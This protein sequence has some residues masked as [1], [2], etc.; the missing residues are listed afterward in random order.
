MFQHISTDRAYTSTIVL[1]SLGVLKFPDCSQTPIPRDESNTVG[2]PAQ[3]RWMGRRGSSPWEL[4]KGSHHPRGLTQPPP[5]PIAMVHNLALVICLPLCPSSCHHGKFVEGQH[6]NKRR[7]RAKELIVL[8]C[9]AG[10]DSK[11]P[12]DSKQIKPVNL[13]RI[14]IGR[15]DAEVEAPILWSPEGKSQF[16]EKDP[17]IGKD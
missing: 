12:S 13:L 1:P 2:V 17:D 15:T 9:G 14:L 5:A 16:T 3:T 4:G 10:E 11:S 8:N 7:L 6:L